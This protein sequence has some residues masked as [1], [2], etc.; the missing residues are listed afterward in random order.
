MRFKWW[1]WPDRWRGGGIM[2]KLKSV[3]ST[4]V[5]SFCA[6]HADCYTHT[7]IIVVLASYFLSHS[8]SLSLFHFVCVSSSLTLS[9]S[10][11]LY[12]FTSI[13]VWISVAHTWLANFVVITSWESAWYSVFSVRCFWPDH[14]TMVVGARRAFQLRG[15]EIRNVAR[16]DTIS[17]SVRWM[18]NHTNSFYQQLRSPLQRSSLVSYI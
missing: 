8:T 7:A 14:A 10:L 17:V 13:S 4:T 2:T 3:S 16:C 11:S 12:Q 1:N 18:R 6:R 9:I 5:C 15:Y